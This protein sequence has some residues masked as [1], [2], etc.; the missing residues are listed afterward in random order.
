MRSVAIHSKMVAWLVLKSVEDADNHSNSGM[1][2]S[3]MPRKFHSAVSAKLSSVVQG[4]RHP[5]QR[6]SGAADLEPH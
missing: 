5:T 2:R 1:S 3:M 6:H 4:L